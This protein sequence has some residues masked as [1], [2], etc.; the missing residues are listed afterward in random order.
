MIEAFGKGVGGKCCWFCHGFMPS[1]FI[2]GAE[3]G[4]RYSSSGLRA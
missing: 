4:E 2:L 3:N 1:H